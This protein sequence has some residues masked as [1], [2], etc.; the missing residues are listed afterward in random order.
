MIILG[1]TGGIACGKSTVSSHLRELGAPIVDADAIAIAL[2]EKGQPVYNAFVEHFGPEIALGPDGSLNRA[3]IGEM[4]FRDKE[5]RRWMDSMTHPLIRSEVENRLKGLVGK[6]TAIAV[7]DVPLLF[8][9]GWENLCEVVWVVSVSPRVQLARLMKRNGLSEK[10]ARDRINSQMALAEKLRRADTVID[11][12]GT[13][14]E[15]RRLVLKAWERLNA[16]QCV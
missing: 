4:V 16:A 2:A 6:G 8:E 12:S 11:N 1:L 9:A 14:E 7:A 5:E 10:L 15:T 13:I 3:A